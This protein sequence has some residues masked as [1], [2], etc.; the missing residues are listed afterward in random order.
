MKRKMAAFLIFFA[1]WICAFSIFIRAEESVYT[2]NIAAIN[3][4]VHTLNSAMD[5]YSE[6]DATEGKCV[7][8]RTN[9]V[10]VRYVNMMNGL[11]ADGRISGEDLSAEVS[12]ITLCGEVSGECAWMFEAHAEELAVA[13]RERAALVYENTLG[14]IA[15]SGSYEALSEAR[16]THLKAVILSIYE[17]KIAALYSAD[18]SRA[19]ADIAERAIR[20]MRELVS[21][22]CA[23]YDGIFER[24]SR[25]MRIQRQKEH[26]IARFAAAYE[27]INGAGSF[28][29]NTDSDDNI[30]HFLYLASEADTVEAFNSALEG[31][32]LRVLEAR[33]GEVRGDH[34]GRLFADMEYGLSVLRSDADAAGEI[35]DAGELFGGV[36]WKIYLSERKDELLLYARETLGDELSDRAAELLDAYNR[37]GGIFDASAD[38]RVADFSLKQAKLRVDWCFECERYEALSAAFFEE[39]KDNIAR[40]FEELYFSI[41]A[42][43]ARSLT[44]EKTREILR[45]GRSAAEECCFALEAEAYSL[46]FSDMIEKPLSDITRTDEIALR[47]AILGYD[48]MSASARELAEAEIVALC[49]KYRAAM[50][51]HLYYIASGDGDRQIALEYSASIDSTPFAES[52]ERFLRFCEVLVKKA[53]SEMRVCEILENITSRDEYTHFTDDYKNALRACRDTYLSRIKEVP[54][55]RTAAESELGVIIRSAELEM[56]R[57]YSEGVIASLADLTDSDEVREIVASAIEGLRFAD[58]TEELERA[59]ECAE[60]DVYR[61]RAK[62]ELSTLKMRGDGALELLAYIG[63]DKRNEYKEGLSVLLS[64]A[65]SA[66]DNAS[67]LS[68]AVELLEEYKAQMQSVC[69]VARAEDLSAAKL[70]AAEQIDARQAGVLSDIEN[71]R[72]A[73]AADK[74]GFALAAERASA[75]ALQNAALCASARD[76]EALVASYVAEMSELAAEAEQLELVCAREQALSAAEERADALLILLDELSYISD[77]RAGAISS[78]ITDA[79]SALADK[80][81]TSDSVAAVESR[82]DEFASAL[83]EKERAA[84]AEDLDFAI[85]ELGGAVEAMRAATAARIGE[86]KYLSEAELA[87]Y[88][89]R[90][91]ELVSGAL[92]RLSAAESVSLAEREWQSAETACGELMLSLLRAE[93]AAA[94]EQAYAALGGAA[95][96]SEARI[97]ALEYLSEAE[98]EGVFADLAALLSEFSSLSQSDATPA[99]VEARLAEYRQKIKALEASAIDRNIA[100]A[101][102]NYTATL[103]AAFAAYKRA[104]YT[105]ER[106]ALISDAYEAARAQLAAASDVE[107]IERIFLAAERE[108][109]EVVSIF[110]DSRAELSERVGAEYREILKNSAQYSEES[111]ARLA[112]IKDRA[113]GELAD[114]ESGIGLDALGAIA[115]AAI[116]EMRGI[117]LDW[118]SVGKLGADSSGFA[119]Y[120]AGYDYSVG[121]V[122]GV[123]ESAGALP[124]DVRLSISL[125]DGN[126]FYKKALR[127]ALAASRVAYVGDVPMSDAE[128]YEHLDGLEIKGIFSIKLIRSAA[129]YDE[130]SGEYTVR[131]LLPAGMRTER[132]LRVVYISPDGDAE[133]YDATCE[134]GMLVFKTAHFSDFV[135]LGERRVNLLPIIGLLAAIGACEGLALVATRR[136]RRRATRLCAAVPM[137]SAVL[138]VIQPK[139]GVA[140]LVTLLAI[141]VTLGVLV[142]MDLRAIGKMRREA[143]T[144]RVYALPVDFEDSTEQAMPLDAS[145]DTPVAALPAYLERV[146]AEDADSLISDS[147]ASALIIRSEIAPKVCRGCKKTFVNVDTLS[148]NFGRGESVS[149]RS[150]KEKGLIPMSACYVKVLARGVIDKPLTVRAQSFSANAVKMITLTGGSAILEG[151]DRE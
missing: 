102:A 51:D 124:S 145:G 83:A 73:P 146:S 109:A 15:A 66:L 89:E 135:V 88:S 18:D 58:S 76:V 29:R 69:E 115:E 70:W 33:V 86:M 34:T 30:A 28:E 47:A 95:D 16:D 138:S 125:S 81:A 77:V 11:R 97:G 3:E 111:L 127:E 45:R 82:L 24:A 21:V 25:E 35:F 143:Q 132:A 112:Q 105:A 50:S 91:D 78:E 104:D 113:L 19:V 54:L 80:L 136:Y 150:L 98:R 65:L 36:S 75:L 85:A 41:D 126:K 121:G 147:R 55:D 27:Q 38:E 93:L 22:D 56:M 49:E 123:V 67:V 116:A 142:A 110:E 131:I 12:L 42:E 31:S 10:I 106:Y 118:I 4:G 46:R 37:D 48:A 13:A 87:D 134:E 62:E 39:P 120:P 43:M 90:L 133:Y 130:F 100:K 114:A 129:V 149:I 26:A 53:E 6:R 151:S 79:L 117:K 9:A 144:A 128:I 140:M 14:A 44:L 71:M 52:G 60:L 20:D 40:Q 59:V 63:T 5:G 108:M 64:D 99:A 96:A 23:D 119:E 84:I 74:E 122:W 107:E 32:L 148:E 61:Q 141:D 101:R 17:E 94:R 8:I 2:K 139:G 103:D 137:P 57:V 92:S 7:A 72:Y 68:R 1:F